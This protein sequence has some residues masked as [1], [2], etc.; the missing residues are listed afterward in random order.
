ML[1]CCSCCFVDNI[2]DVSDQQ[3]ELL[4]K[5]HD[6]TNAQF[7]SITDDLGIQQ[8]QQQKTEVKLGKCYVIPLQIY[9]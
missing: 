3:S 8:Q 2:K 9:P 7:K 4:T 5:I 1:P 6:D